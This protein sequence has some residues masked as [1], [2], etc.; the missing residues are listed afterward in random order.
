[1]KKAMSILLALAMIFALA[2]C[3]TTDT[4]PTATTDPAADAS[5]DP[6][7]ETSGSELNYPEKDI[8]LIIPFAAGGVTDLGARIV[9]RY[10]SE[11]VG[12]DINC[13]NITG[14]SGAVGMQECMNKDP[15]GYSLVI[16]ASS[17]PMH[18]ALGTFELSYD[19]FECVAGLFSNLQCICVRA[20]S[21]IETIDD[22]IDALKNDSSLKYGAFTNS[23]ALGVI[24]AIEDY[25]GTTVNLVDVAEE[26]KTT[27]LLAGRIDVLS[28]FVSSVMPYIESGDFRCIGVFADERLEELPDVPTFKEA[29]IDY[30]IT[31]PYFGL[32]ATK[33]TDPEIVEFL[34]EKIGECFANEPQMAEELA[35]L[36][37]VAD[38]KPSSEYY[39]TLKSIFDD[40]ETFVDA[41][42]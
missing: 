35:E 30:S 34:S 40:F 20:D 4:T 18:N 21:D 2:A 7:T 22:L 31:I 11:Y 9:A 23:I 3:G 24:L 17:M 16:Q 41:R 32:M 26:S 8:E 10:L 13:L 5:A 1:M 28:D 42:G 33:G 37:Y 15:D 38:Y 25:I 36:S 14:A 29:G 19:D 6:G 39:D 12:V 27:E